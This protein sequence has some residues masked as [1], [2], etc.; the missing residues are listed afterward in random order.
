MIY[1]LLGGLTPFYPPLLQRPRTQRQRAREQ[2]DNALGQLQGLPGISRR[3]GYPQAPI[4][5]STKK[6]TTASAC[7][8]QRNTVA[9]ESRAWEAIRHLRGGRKHQGAN[10]R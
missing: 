4:P 5:R 3:A 7:Q 6:Q 2:R 8:A 10:L 1:L 9:A